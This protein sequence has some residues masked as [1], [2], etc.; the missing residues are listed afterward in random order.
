MA[1]YKSKTVKK[2]VQIKSFKVS[3]ESNLFAFLS[4]VMHEKSRTTLKSIL[5]NQLIAVNGIGQTNVHFLLKP[6]DVVSYGQR[7]QKAIDLPFNIDIVYEDQVLIV[8]NKP[9]GLLTISSEKEKKKTMYAYLSFYLKQKDPNAKIFIVHRLDR[10]TSGILVFAKS[11]DIKTLLQ[12]NWSDENKS[13]KYVALVEG[14]VKLKEGT[15][16]SYLRESKALKVHSS[17]NATYGKESITHYKV[18]GYKKNS[19]LLEITLETGRKN[20]IRVHME[21]LGHPIVGDK[22]YGAKTNPIGRLGL[23]ALELGFKHPT[24]GK[25]LNFKTKIP[26]KLVVKKGD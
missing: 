18:L 16:N 17:K 3:E 5:K 1:I 24:S 11:M 12:N 6:G 4:K 26:S 10:E 20:Q 19:T 23:H 15:I 7:A 9:E 22:K 14:L 13:R 8:V 21:E 25:I 2:S